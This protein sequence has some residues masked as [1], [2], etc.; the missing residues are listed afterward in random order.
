MTPLEKKKEKVAV[1]DYLRK[2]P[3]C[4]Y[5]KL[6]AAVGAESLSKPVF[7][8]I[9]GALRKSGAIPGGTASK[10]GRNRAGA[11]PSKM[12]P[13]SSPAS[14]GTRIEILHTLT[15]GLSAEMR[16]HWKSTVLPVLKSLVP[17]GDG[18]SLAFLSEPE[19][20]EIRRALR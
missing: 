11:T 12:A 18:I 14:S 16:E 1:R 6:V 3:D 13:V 19:T 2:Y 5:E 20:M 10:S 17:D 8:N 9:R 7:Y 4:S 15:V